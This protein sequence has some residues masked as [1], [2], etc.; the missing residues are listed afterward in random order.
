[1]FTLTPEENSSIIALGQRIVIEGEVSIVS[2]VSHRKFNLGSILSENNIKPGKL[3]VGSRVLL[4]SGDVYNDTT[5]INNWK[6]GFT[7]DEVADEIGDVS[8]ELFA[9]DNSTL[10]G[11]EVVTLS[12]KLVVLTLT[13]EGEP[14]CIEL[15]KVATIQKNRL[16]VNSGVI[17]LME[18][19]DGVNED[20][21]E[22]VDLETRRARHNE[23]FRSLLGLP[24][25]DVCSRLYK[26]SDSILQR[27]IYLQEDIERIER[28]IQ[29]RLLQESRRKYQY[30]DMTKLVSGVVIDSDSGSPFIFSGY[31]FKRQVPDTN[32][33][34][35]SDFRSDSSIGSLNLSNSL[36]YRVDELNVYAVY[37][38]LETYLRIKKERNDTLV[39]AGN[40]LV[41]TLMGRETV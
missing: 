11:Y 36:V 15:E 26:S 39:A 17:K 19:K 25:S 24:L 31:P 1:M 30:F 37:P 33:L 20:P 32:Y 12:N 27:N 23:F 5:P 7:I 28:K 3:V 22:E 40:L 29:V 8:A 16:V 34:I 41:T 14:R 2:D 4:K 35:L 13:T 21:T 9:P 6:N 10:L 18:E 38:D